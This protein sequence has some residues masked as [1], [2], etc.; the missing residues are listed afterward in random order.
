MTSNSFRDFYFVTAFDLDI[1]GLVKLA[2]SKI[3]DI[4]TFLIPFYINKS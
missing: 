4:K 3:D 1:D 2:N